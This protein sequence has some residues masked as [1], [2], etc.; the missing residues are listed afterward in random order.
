MRNDLINDLR[1]VVAAG[2]VVVLALPAW[3]QSPSAS[4]SLWQESGL[5]SSGASSVWNCEGF[6]ASSEPWETAWASLHVE[7][8]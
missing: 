5:Q 8:G 2:A 7:S 1:T 3:A 4:V 6:A